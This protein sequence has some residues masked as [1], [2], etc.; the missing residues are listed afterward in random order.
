[1][2]ELKSV[3][4]MIRLSLSEVRRIIYDLRPMALDDLGLIPAIRKYVSTTADYHNIE[5][6]FI[7]IGKQIRL[8]QEYEI[9]FFRLL[10]ESLQNA[11]KHAEAKLIQ[12]KLIID[13]DYLVLIIHDH[14]KG[15]NPEKR[16]EKSFGIIGMKERV[17]MLRGTLEI[18]SKLNEG[19]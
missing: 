9:A 19:T 2:Q 18:K 4:E 1:M 17:E 6:K 15:F 8:K 7:H 10:Q 14:G 12:V 5:I 13:Y 11:I 16:R 3:R